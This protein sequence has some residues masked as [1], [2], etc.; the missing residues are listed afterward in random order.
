MTPTEL[1]KDDLIVHQRGYFDQLSF[2]RQQNLPVT[3]DYL[4]KL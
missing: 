3:D 1:V 4:A 2:F